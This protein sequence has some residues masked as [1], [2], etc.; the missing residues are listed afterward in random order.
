MYNLIELAA[1]ALRAK[2][3]GPDRIFVVYTMTIKKRTVQTINDD[4]SRLERF[5]SKAPSRQQAHV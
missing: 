3:S 1:G 2:Q 5:S 4:V